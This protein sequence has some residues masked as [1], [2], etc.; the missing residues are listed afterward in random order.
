LF[1]FFLESYDRFL[2][3]VRRDHQARQQVTDFFYQ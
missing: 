1:S 2:F 3:R